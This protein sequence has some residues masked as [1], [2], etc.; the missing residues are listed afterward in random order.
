MP[1]RFRNTVIT[2]L[3]LVFSYHAYATSLPDAFSQ[4]VLATGASIGLDG[5]VTIGSIRFVPL[6]PP[7]YDPSRVTDTAKIADC[8]LTRDQVSYL[9][10]GAIQFVPIQYESSQSSHF[11]PGLALMPGYTLPDDFEVPDSFIL[12]R[13]L[14]MPAGATSSFSDPATASNASSSSGIVEV[15]LEAKIA[16][17]N[18]NGIVANLVTYNGQFP[19]PTIKVKRG[20]VLKVH[21]KNSLPNLG[22]NLLGHQLST[23]N[24][25]TH[26]FHVSPLGNSDNPM[27]SITSGQAFDYVFDLAQHPAGNLDYY[28]PHSHGVA[29]DQVW[30]GMAGAIEVADDNAALAEF[31]THTLILK[32]IQLDSA[33]IRPHTSL[34]EY[35]AGKEGDVVMVNGRVNPRLKVSPGQVQRWR[36][37]NASTARFYKLALTGHNFEVIGTDG[38]LLNKPYPLNSIIVSPGERLDV[39]IKASNTLGSYKLVALP[40][41]RGNGLNT[42]ATIMTT[43]V[44]GTPI[45]QSIPATIN[46][47]AVRMSV[48]AGTLSRR[49]VLNMN[50]MGAGSGMMGSGTTTMATINGIGF[51]DTSAFTINSSLGS[52]EVWEVINQTAMDHPFHLH[53]NSAQVLSITGGDS[54]YAAFYT[55]VPAHKDTVIVPA[56]GNITLLVPSTDFA[57]ATLF[58]CHILEHEDIGMMGLWKISQ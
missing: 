19:A 27:L 38:G 51:S 30:G 57:G 20:D 10:S 17:I 23:T 55:S 34:M 42:Q 1:K 50:M 29:A 47:S 58:H 37:L 25:H 49:L 5:S 26:G 18:I 53:V 40:Y 12:P 31:E 15:G 6:L 11:P 43:V 48:P 45:N 39:L 16:A 3:A 35:M 41:D 8:N 4:S 14:T 33:Q 36:I 9:C 52:Y 22:K 21:F 28:H 7:L 44:S 2:A 54:S 46:P 24:L 32:D 13:G 56:W